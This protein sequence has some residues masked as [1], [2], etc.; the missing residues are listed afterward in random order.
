MFTFSRA[1][2]HETPR[3]AARIGA[4]IFL[5]YMTLGIVGASAR[6]QEMSSGSCIGSL[7]SLDCATRWGWADDPFI[8]V[9]PPPVDEAARARASERKR[10]W[11]Y[12]C[13][14]SVKQD[15]YGVARYH[16]AEPGCE[17]GAGEY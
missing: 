13:R 10:R 4:A 5:S 1:R 11:A 16:Y 8:R 9:V 12:R 2:A 15:R 7:S 3:S 17:F 6:A 14:P